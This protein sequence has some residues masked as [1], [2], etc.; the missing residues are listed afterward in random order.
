MKAFTK[1]ICSLVLLA[2]MP[3]LAVAPPAW[4]NFQGRLL[5]S[6]GVPVTQS[7]M[8]FIVSIWS[9]PTST[10][11]PAHLKY[12]ESHVVNVDD[13][14]Y[15]FP[16]GS[17]TPVPCTGCGYGASLYA[18]NTT[19]WLEITVQGETLSPRH[20]L[21]SAPYT[22]HAGN[23]ENLGGQPA[24]YFGTAATDNYLQGQINGLQDQINNLPPGGG[25]GL[26]SLCVA[27]GNIWDR[28]KG[29]CEKGIK[30][31]DH[32]GKIVPVDQNG[33]ELASPDFEKECLQK[34]YRPIRDSRG[35]PLTV[36][37]C[38]A[39]PIEPPGQYGC[40]F[41][42][43]SSAITIKLKDCPFMLEVKEGEP[44]KG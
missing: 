23:S 9:D 35:D 32:Q 14:V 10:N 8:A 31:M 37:N 13:G 29:L 30:V 24:G 6:S 1:V 16:V 17:G 21:L 20:R 26:E 12:R 11:Q 22:N 44:P 36:F 34:H 25:A 43:M 2:A 28:D 18:N 15:S 40:G 27:T 7:N 19:L 5:N 39:D 4:I 42:S 3:V 41:G 38:D 33:V